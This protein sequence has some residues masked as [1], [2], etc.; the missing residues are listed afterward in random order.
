MVAIWA[1][2]RLI[3]EPWPVRW[4]LRFSA[5]R[6]WLLS[7]VARENFDFTEA[8]RFAVRSQRKFSAKVC[9]KARC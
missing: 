8:A 2:M 3:R 6:G 7:L 5:F 1:M 9:R 4:K